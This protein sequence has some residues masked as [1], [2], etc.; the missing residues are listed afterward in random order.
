MV[1]LTDND[2]AHEH[3]YRSEQQQADDE[4]VYMKPVQQQPQLR[5]ALMHLIECDK[6]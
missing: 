1:V 2:D 4:F 6:N 5:L 3:R